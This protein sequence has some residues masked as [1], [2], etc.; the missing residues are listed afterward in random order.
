MKDKL[1]NESKRHMEMSPR[2]QHVTKHSIENDILRDKDTKRRVGELETLVE[3][4]RE[5]I[6]Y[7]KELI[8][9]LQNEKSSN[10]IELKEQLTK[11]QVQANKLKE[12][13]E[14]LKKDH[15]SM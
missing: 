12:N 2:V 15:D 6:T 14:Q 1:K 11:E 7:N 9:K 4:L 13:Y 5:E 8:V 10:E 3:T